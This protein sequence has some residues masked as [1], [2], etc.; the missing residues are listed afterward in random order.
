[1]KN[2]WQNHDW[3]PM[4][5]KEIQKPFDS[6][7]YIFEIK[8][9]GIRAV[10]FASPK[11]V[12]VQTRNKKD[13]THLFPEL[14]SIKDLVSKNTIFDGEIVSFVNGKSSFSKLQEREHLKNTIKI[15]EKS[16]SDPV[17]FVCFDILYENKDL[18]NLSLMERKEILKKYKENDYFMKNKYIEKRGKDLFKSVKKL[19]LEGIIAKKG[20]SN[21]LIDKRSFNWIKIKNL[22]KDTFY[23][24]GFTDTNKN[25]S[26]TLY[27][28]SYKKN[29]LMFLGKVSM[30]KRHKLYNKIIKSNLRKTSSFSD[31]KE[32]IKYI[33]P[34]Y[35]CLVKYL[36]KT[37]NGHL[38]QPI[39]IEEVI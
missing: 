16:K 32:D 11:K 25:E 4:L 29:K 36:E 30:N 9:D 26:I 23:I 22:K 2:I 6:D 20:D 34:K 7:D 31:Y 27:L 14:A 10:I 19:G 35:K 28:G 18:T 15:N 21:Y 39:F 5:L 13:I 24:G 33:T 1:M 3:V 8:F 37:K 17:V 12:V 38:R